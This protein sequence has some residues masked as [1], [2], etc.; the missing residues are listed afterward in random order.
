MK[1]EQEDEAT[2]SCKKNQSECRCSGGFIGTGQHF[3]H[4]KKNRKWHRRFF[5]VDNIV[6][7]PPGFGKSSVTH[8]SA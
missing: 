2:T 8:H 3:L 4:K 6:L 7:L 1:D 5:S